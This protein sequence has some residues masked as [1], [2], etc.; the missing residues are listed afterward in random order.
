[1]KAIALFMLAILFNGSAVAENELR[2]QKIARIA[3]AQGLHQM[4]Q[5]QLDQSKSAATQYGRDIY[6]T[7]V[8]ELGLPDGRVNPKLEAAFRRYVDRC[9]SMWSAKG[10][11]DTRS[12]N[13]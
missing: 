11:V 6:Q 3:I 4:F 9:A 7:M 12:T 5:Q 13:Y 10:L 8:A 2:Q 1:M